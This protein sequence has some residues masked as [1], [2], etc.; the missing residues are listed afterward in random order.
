MITIEKGYVINLPESIQ[1]YK[2]FQEESKLTKIP[3]ERIDGMDG[4]PYAR[5]HQASYISGSIGNILANINALRKAKTE[6]IRHLLL[7]E[8]DAQ[9]SHNF[10]EYLQEALND[11]PEDYFIVK[12][13]CIF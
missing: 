13:A 6:G 4:K 12:T 2:L 9:L 10:D 5:S 8:D 11:L 7:F 1:R 3:I